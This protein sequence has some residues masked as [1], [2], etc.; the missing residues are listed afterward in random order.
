MADPADLA[1][2]IKDVAGTVEALVSDL[3]GA[4]SEFAKP[5]Q[6]MAEL[7]KRVFERQLEFER[8]VVTRVVEPAR[9]TLKLSEQATAAF[10]D[11]ASAFRAASESLGE[12]ADLT[13][14]QAELAEQASGVVQDTLGVLRSAAETLSGKNKD[15]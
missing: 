13:D 4:A 15:S 1:T 10:H 9:V 8:D 14:R 6:R 7:L 2:A 3:T 11:Q 12:L 5:R